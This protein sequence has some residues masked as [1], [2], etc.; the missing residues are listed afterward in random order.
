MS[1]SREPV[2]RQNELGFSV[3]ANESGAKTSGFTKDNTYYY[4]IQSEEQIISLE[5]DV[6][7]E[8]EVVTFDG[9]ADAS[10]V[11]FAAIYDS[12]AS[13]LYTP[14]FELGEFLSRP[15]RLY[16]YTISPGA[17]FATVTQNVWTD[18]LGNTRIKKKIDN[19]AYIQCKL[20]IKVVVNSTPFVF[21]LLGIS[22][23]PLPTFN[24]ISDNNVDKIL[25]SQRP[26]IWLNLSKSQGGEM[27]FP[28]FYPKNWLEISAAA[29]TD[30][31]GQ[32]KIWQVVQA[33]VAN[34]GITATPSVTVYAWAEDVRLYGNTINVS[35]QSAESEYG[36]AI[37]GPASTVSKIASYFSDI[38]FIG[39][40]AKATTIGAG[41]VASI[42]S[43]FGYSNVPVIKDAEPLKSMPFHGLASAHI[44]NVVEKLTLD[45]QNELSISPTTV[46]LPAGDELAI[47]NLVSRTAI[48]AIPTWATTDAFNAL[49]FAANVT[50]THCKTDNSTP[51]QVILTETPLAMVTRLFSEWRGDILYH[52]KVIKTP[53][54]RGRLIVNYDPTGDIIT[55]S[56]NNNV[57]QTVIVDIDEIDEFTIRVPY[58]VPTS[59]QNCIQTPQPDFA[60]NGGAMNSYD[61]N[62]HNGRLTI[63]VLNNLTAPLDTATISLVISVSGAEN[64]EFGNPSDIFFDGVGGALPSA[65][66]I[67]SAEENLEK[68]YC[69]GRSRPTPDHVYDINFGERIASLREILRRS[70]FVNREKISTNTGSSGLDNYYIVHTKYPN[71]YGYDPNGIHGA[72]QTNGI[73]LDVN[74]NFV[75][76]GPFQWIQGCFVGMRGST[77]WHYD[78]LDLS[79]IPSMKVRR[80]A[81]FNVN[82]TNVVTRTNLRVLTAD[83]VTGSYSTTSRNSMTL[84]TAGSCGQAL[85]HQATQT[86]LSVLYPQYNK[87][88]FISAYPQNTTYG[89]LG[90]SSIYE[91]FVLDIITPN[92][93]GVYKA[94]DRYFSIG[95]DFNFFFFLNTPP[96][97]LYAVPSA[98]L[99]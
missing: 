60:I 53:Y 20:K 17:P 72:R 36:G 82:G 67:Q 24:P 26:T 71:T 70:A 14:N 65:W 35:I 43:M 48:I 99:F 86:G 27:E 62:V 78:G 3:V 74:F 38:P 75:S 88:R 77:I 98:A 46:G 69:M 32:F 56:D 89:S 66:A 63:R 51:N 29:N 80:L 33:A 7:V 97:Y 95:P 55:T 40:F 18:F 79:N 11:N 96:R 8:E 15:T 28:F 61:G 94:V 87:F 5:K 57:V 23:Q 84:T 10:K 68:E 16:H 19:Y 4:I 93:N 6:T 47:S 41:A 54:H 22:Y 59:F 73:I 44:S 12:V 45:P 83:I 76:P 21:G 64:I 42:A 58:M 85:V 13:D 2:P 52:V 39:R 90:D 49:L 30:G 37:S 31:M 1:G 9:Q 50:P 92:K 91:R 81:T 34:S 25:I